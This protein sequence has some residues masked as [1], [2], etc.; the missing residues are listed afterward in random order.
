M[1]SKEEK[2]REAHLSNDAQ[3]KARERGKE[4][5]LFSENGKRERNELASDSLHSPF[6]FGGTFSFSSSM[7]P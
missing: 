7:T 5:I 6:L 1:R 2:K 3:Q 4:G